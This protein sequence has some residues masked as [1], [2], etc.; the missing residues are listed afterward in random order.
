MIKS[1]EI[2]QQ[3]EDPKKSQLKISRVSKYI[4]NCF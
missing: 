2:L 1:P 4:K 3:V